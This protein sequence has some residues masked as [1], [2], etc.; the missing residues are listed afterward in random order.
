MNLRVGYSYS[1]GI[2]FSYLLKIRSEWLNVRSVTVC[3]DHTYPL[4]S[5]EDPC[6]LRTL[7]RRDLIGNGFPIEI[8]PRS[9]WRTLKRDCVRSRAC[10]ARR[11]NK[12]G[13][14][15]SR[16]R[17]LDGEAARRRDGEM[18]HKVAYLR[19]FA[20]SLLKSLR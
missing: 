7:T 6:I 10:Y 8:L 16:G 13:R 4:A 19:G 1:L 5:H 11:G 2:I 9:S 17:R 12:V 15:A 18:R 20:W 3:R 14:S